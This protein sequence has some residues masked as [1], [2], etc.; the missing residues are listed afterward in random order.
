MNNL[1]LVPS[2]ENE[3][4]LSFILSLSSSAKDLSHI[5]IYTS[6]DFTR[7]SNLLIL[8]LALPRIFI[9][10]ACFPIFL[11]LYLYLYI[12]IYLFSDYFNAP[13]IIADENARTNTE[14]KNQIC[15]YSWLLPTASSQMK[16][17]PCSVWSDLRVSDTC[18]SSSSM[19]HTPPV[20]I[21]GPGLVLFPFVHF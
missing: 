12:Y 3:H 13:I 10:R 18:H 1:D 6:S 4:R 14:T 9:I 5:P 20:I 8:F 17:L 7:F 19:T 16:R 2:P 15:L 21:I 11:F